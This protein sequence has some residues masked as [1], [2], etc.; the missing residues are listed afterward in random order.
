M[1]ENNG[2]RRSTGSD[3][4]AIMRQLAPYLTLGTQLTVTVLFLGAIGWWIDDSYGSEPWGLV[5]GLFA[6][7][8]IGFYQFL[9]SLQDLLKR[10]KEKQSK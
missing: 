6:G 3:S 4:G 5:I 7:C 1:P 2:K 10:D 8:G 9:K